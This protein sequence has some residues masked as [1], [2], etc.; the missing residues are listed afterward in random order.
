MRYLNRISPNMP[1]LAHS[2]MNITYS[3]LFAG[4]VGA[5]S[6]FLVRRDSKLLEADCQRSTKGSRVSVNNGRLRW[7][8][9]NVK[10]ANGRTADSP[11]LITL[12]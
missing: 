10:K 2:S 3:V 9:R 8:K 4:M 1:L 11:R 7:R 6:L 5:G 12:P